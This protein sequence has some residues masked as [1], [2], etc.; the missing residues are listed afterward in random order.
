MWNQQPRLPNKYLDLNE[1]KDLVPNKY[2]E[3]NEFKDLG[4]PFKNHYNMVQGKTFPIGT[5]IP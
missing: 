1:F 5:A 3:I 2:L 4:F